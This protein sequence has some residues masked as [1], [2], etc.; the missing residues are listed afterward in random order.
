M[1]KEKLKIIFDNIIQNYNNFEF[2]FEVI[3]Q[4]EEYTDW[5]G[6]GERHTKFIR[7][8]TIVDKKPKIEKIKE[9]IW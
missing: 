7:T 2:E 1:P 6:N 4:I 9:N 8:I 5:N 3:P